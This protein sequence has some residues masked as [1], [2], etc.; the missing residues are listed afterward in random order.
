MSNPILESVVIISILASLPIL[1][2]RSLYLSF[3]FIAIAFFSKD[4]EIL[5][6]ISK[7]FIPLLNFIL[8]PSGKVIEIFILF[9]ILLILILS[10]SIL[11]HL[12]YLLL[13]RLNLK[14]FF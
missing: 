14:V 5:F 8:F 12:G 4:L 6:A 13:P 7:P 3:T 10:N 9:S 11:H 1:S 2:V